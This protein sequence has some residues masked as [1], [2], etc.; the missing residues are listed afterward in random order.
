MKS[1]VCGRVGVITVSALLFST[2]S[3]DKTADKNQDSEETKVNSNRTS[4]VQHGK[5][6]RTAAT[7]RVRD[8]TR[9]D[10][11]Q[12]CRTPP[13]RSWIS[14]TITL[15]HSG[16]SSTITRGG[17]TWTHWSHS[18]WRSFS[19]R[20]TWTRRSTTCSSAATSLVRLSITRTWSQ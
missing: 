3:V 15:Y 4:Y 10:A 6:V 2:G 5:E 11:S 1:I 19:T 20:A 17:N 16:C 13:P 9:S 14:P 8:V 18:A 7:A 12:I